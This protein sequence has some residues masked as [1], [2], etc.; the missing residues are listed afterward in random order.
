MA[1]TK[2]EIVNKMW[3]FC[4]ILLDDG[5][6][7]GDYVEQLTYLLFLKMA[8]EQTKLL[9]KENLIKWQLKVDEIL[10]QADHL[11]RGHKVTFDN[12]GNKQWQVPT[13]PDEITLNDYGVSVIMRIMS[14]MLDNPDESGIYPTGRFMDRIE[15]LLESMMAAPDAMQLS[16][17]EAVYGFSAWLTCQNREVIAGAHHDAAIWAEL[18]DTFCKANNLSEPREQWS[19]LLVHPE[20]LPAEETA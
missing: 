4:T 10:E 12:Q 6:S 5:V 9:K 7:Y 16:G 14:E 11:L 20:P 2:N 8:D 15:A 13:D 3:G 19:T 18:V 1:K 17:S